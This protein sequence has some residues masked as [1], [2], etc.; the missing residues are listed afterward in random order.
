MV[1]QNDVNGPTR[2]FTPQQIGGAVQALPAE[3][4]EAWR[5]S[6]A[7]KQKLLDL[8]SQMLGTSRQPCRLYRQVPSE[9]GRSFCGLRHVRYVLGDLICSGG[10]LDNAARDFLGRGAL[11]L[12]R[13]RNADLGGSDAFNGL[14]DLR[15]GAHCL[16]RVVPDGLNLRRYLFG[17]LG[18]LICEAFHFRGL[19]RQSLYRRHRPERLQLSR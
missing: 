2:D 10:S 9:F 12:Y 15:D 17:R 4:N 6:S 18:G 8:T 11:L 3:A 7:A 5:Q 16:A 19:Q 13:S 14:D 1:L